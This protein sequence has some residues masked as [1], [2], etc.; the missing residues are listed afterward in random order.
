[1]DIKLATRRIAPYKRL[2]VGD[3]VYIKESGGP[4]MGRVTVTECDDY[5]FRD[6]YD[7]R[8]LL[9][10]VWEP[11]GLDSKEHA[12]R[13]W[14]KKSHMKYATVF[15]FDDAVKLENPI[16]II[17]HDRRVWISDYVLPPQ[18]RMTFN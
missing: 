1:M 6:S 13:M 2:K 8:N 16:K 17:K 9:V 7:L 11:I 3:H 10:D 14:Q 4:V 15:W 12:I 18:L 5:E